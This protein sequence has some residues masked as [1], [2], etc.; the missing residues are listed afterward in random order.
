M[1]QE[2]IFNRNQAIGL[3]I[4]EDSGSQQW[5]GVM[6]TYHKLPLRIDNQW[7][8]PY[9]YE[10]DFNFHDSWEWLMPV[11]ERLLKQK[12][13]QNRED[14]TVVVQDFLIDPHFVHLFGYIY[15]QEKEPIEFRS[16]QFYG[17]NDFKDT[18]SS[19]LE[20]VWLAVSDFCLL[21]NQIYGQANH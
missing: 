13:H 21:Y 2:E 4:S 15:N 16:R 9:H 5:G 6:H 10:E 20:M 1:T 17:D 7:G 14:R 11:V 18:A 12:F 8:R 19:F 3:W